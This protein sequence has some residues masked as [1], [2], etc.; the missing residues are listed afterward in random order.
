MSKVRREG[1]LKRNGYRKTE[2]RNYGY[3]DIKQI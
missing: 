3:F 2:E 1:E